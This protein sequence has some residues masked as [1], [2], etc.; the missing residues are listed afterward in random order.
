MLVPFLKGWVTLYCVSRP[1]RHSRLGAPCANMRCGAPAFWTRLRRP[2]G[3]QAPHQQLSGIL[4]FRKN[5]ARVHRR[6][7]GQWSER[8]DHPGRENGPECRMPLQFPRHRTVNN[9]RR[10]R[11]NR[12]QHAPARRPRSSRSRRSKKKPLKSEWTISFEKGRGQNRRKP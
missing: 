10:E 5:L 7:N 4:P 8:S 11:E 9:T 2:R 1:M 12:R 3:Y 6:A